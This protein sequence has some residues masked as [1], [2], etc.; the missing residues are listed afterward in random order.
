M[1]DNIIYTFYISIDNTNIIIVNS[2]GHDNPVLKI[3]HHDSP[4]FNNT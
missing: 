4:N 2:S 1:T 3:R